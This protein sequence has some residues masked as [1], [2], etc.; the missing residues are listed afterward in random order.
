MDGSFIFISSHVAAETSNLVLLQPRNVALLIVEVLTKSVENYLG[1][2]LNVSHPGNKL[3]LQLLL[4]IYLTYFVC[5][6]L[7]LP[8]SNFNETITK[9]VVSFVIK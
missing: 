2:V 5:Q 7:H 4:T 3:P 8:I 6:F 9:H 1:W